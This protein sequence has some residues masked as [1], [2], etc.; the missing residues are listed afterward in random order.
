MNIDNNNKKTT[1]T[2]KKRAQLIVEKSKM[3]SIA[4]YIVDRLDEEPC[5]DDELEPE[6]TLFLQTH[7]LLEATCSSYNAI[8]LDLFSV[9]LSRSSELLRFLQVR[10]RVPRSLEIS[11]CG[12]LSAS[13]LQPL[14]APAQWPLKT[15]TISGCPL[16]ASC[17]SALLSSLPVLPRLASLT[18]ANCSLSSEMALSFIDF[19]S[20]TSP[21][22]SSNV[23]TLPHTSSSSS[24][25]LS[26]SQLI[27]V[28]L[29]HNPHI[30]DG[31]LSRLLVISLRRLRRLVLSGCQVSEA[32]LRELLTAVQS[33]SPSEGRLE[34]LL[35]DQNPDLSLDLALR[36][37]TP[38]LPLRTLNLS[39]SAIS[40]EDASVFDCLPEALLSHPFLEK[41]ELGPLFPSQG[42]AHQ[43]SELLARNRCNN[44]RRMPLSIQVA[45][46][47]YLQD[48]DVSSL[49]SASRLFY[50]RTAVPFFQFDDD[51]EEGQLSSDSESDLLGV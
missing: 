9:D 6:E 27:D 17:F 41:I 37:I 15:L 14:L 35:L 16:D 24:S 10:C 34:E 48:L 12:P 30:G 33:L 3:N 38:S 5:S 49:P 13:V 25:S 18:L 2:K 42:V 47:I 21:D 44:R 20:S 4:E 19:L 32:P 40:A 45:H 31:P 8:S 23:S 11:E 28:D 1:E 26:S 51:Q 43:V 39:W 29:Q 7:G 22:L 46:T 50:K 36:C